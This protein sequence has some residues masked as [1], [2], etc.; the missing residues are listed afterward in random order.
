MTVRRYT[1]T[2]KDRET[3]EERQIWIT[4][5]LLKILIRAVRQYSSAPQYLAE[6]FTFPS[7]YRR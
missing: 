1:L 6:F 7:R 3:G 5:S 2:I 4:H